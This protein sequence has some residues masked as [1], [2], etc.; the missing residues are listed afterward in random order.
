M[1]SAS[2][3][4]GSDCQNSLDQDSFFISQAKVIILGDS[5]VGKTSII[6]RFIKD[7]FSS[8]IQCTYGNKN[9]KYKLIDYLFWFKV[10]TF[11]QKKLKPMIEM[12]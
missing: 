1:S 7:D 6:I 4:S 12:N 9:K 5:A 10:L 8:N 3:F 11:I 2:S